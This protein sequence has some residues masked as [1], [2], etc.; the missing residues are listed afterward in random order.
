MMIVSHGATRTF[1]YVIAAIGASGLLQ[2]F[3]HTDRAVTQWFAERSTASGYLG[4]CSRSTSGQL[5]TGSGMSATDSGCPQGRPGV[6]PS[7]SHGIPDGSGARPAVAATL[8]I[9][10][11]ASG[12]KASRSLLPT[13][14]TS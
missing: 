13:R 7:I 14:L 1:K 9:C 3:F 6:M 12:R 11:L 10:S 2:F 8:V 4:V 5:P